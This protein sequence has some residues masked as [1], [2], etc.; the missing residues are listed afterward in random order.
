M[1]VGT[2]VVKEDQSKYGDAGEGNVWA[3]QPGTNAVTKVKDPSSNNN[4][5]NNNNTRSS[6]VT[7][8]STV[9]VQDQINKQIKDATDSSGNVD[10][11]K[12]DVGA[13]VKQREAGVT[14][15]NNDN[16]NDSGGGGG[17]GGWGG[18]GCYVATALNDGGYW[19]TSKKLKLIKWCIEAKPENKLD[20]K[21]WRNGYVVFGKNVIAPKID[22][23]IIQWLSNGFY[24]A[25]VQKETNLQ[26]VLGKLFFYIPSYSIGL[27]KALRGNLVD[28][29][30]T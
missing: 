3:V 9:N 27:W 28:I 30:R 21:L 7:S 8:T 15:T 20:T 10:W 19:S 11:T 14:T 17:G 26:A 6:T 18:Y 29:E 16:D 12:A 5:N 25:T 24:C 1:Q 22:N 23:K 2:A 4:N 13:L